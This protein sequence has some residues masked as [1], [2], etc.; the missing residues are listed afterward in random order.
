VWTDVL[1]C[2]ILSD[3]CAG[4]FVTEAEVHPFPHFGLR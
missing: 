2:P 4:Q 1:S 3:F